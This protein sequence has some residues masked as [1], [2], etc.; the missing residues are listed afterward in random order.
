MASAEPQPELPDPVV[1]PTSPRLLGLVGPGLVTGASDDDPSGIATYSQA[2]AKFGYAVSWTLLLTYPLMV[3]IQIISA[4]ERRAG[5]WPEIS[6]GVIR[7]GSSL[8][9]QFRF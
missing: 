6:F 1:E 8:A 5:D 2:G 3:A 4:E 9:R 7:H